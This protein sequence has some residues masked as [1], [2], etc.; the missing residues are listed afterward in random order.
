MNIVRIIVMGFVTV[1]VAFAL[2]GCTFRFQGSEVEMEGQVVREY[3]FD[4][5]EID[6]I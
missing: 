4:G 1:L 2:V 6:G 5:V 3:E